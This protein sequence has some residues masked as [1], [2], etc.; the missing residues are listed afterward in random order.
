MLLPASGNL[1]LTGTCI[2]KLL[3]NIF[4]AAHTSALS[5]CQ[6]PLEVEHEVYS[7]QYMEIGSKLSSGPESG[8]LPCILK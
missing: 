1:Q 4:I 5:T 8:I 2:V 7:E 3:L 6:M